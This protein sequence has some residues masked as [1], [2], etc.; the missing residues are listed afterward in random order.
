MC[1]YDSGIGGMLR[2]LLKRRGYT[3]GG[4]SAAYMAV[5]FFFFFA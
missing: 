2:G 3:N 4:F 1:V 5:S